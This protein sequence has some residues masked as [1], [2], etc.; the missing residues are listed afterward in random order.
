SSTYHPPPIAVSRVVHAAAMSEHDIVS[1]RSQRSSRLLIDRR[2]F[3][4]RPPGPIHVVASSDD[5]HSIA[6]HA[7]GARRAAVPGER[8]MRLGGRLLE[9]VDPGAAACGGRARQR[10]G[11]QLKPFAVDFARRP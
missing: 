3:P 9:V 11:P 1:T 2:P 10:A 5:A 6:G 8:V 4:E 7:G